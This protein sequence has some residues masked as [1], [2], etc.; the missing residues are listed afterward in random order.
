M[1]LQYIPISNL[2][3]V[4]F[5]GREFFRVLFVYHS[6]AQAELVNRIDAKFMFVGLV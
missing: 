6:F 2:T 1:Q 4:L 5:T 3:H